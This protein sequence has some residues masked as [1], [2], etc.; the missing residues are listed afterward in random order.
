MPN[1]VSS[2]IRSVRF[3]RH[4]LFLSIAVCGGA[5]GA[6]AQTTVTLS[7][8]AHIN[9]DLTIQGGN[10]ARVDFSD[11][12]SLATKVSSEAYTRRILMK[13]DTEHYIPANA[14]IKSA[15]LQLVLKKAENSERRPLTA[16]YVT[17]SF[18]KRQANWLYYRDG[19]P[20]SRRGGDLG[21]KFGVTYVGNAVG[22][23]YTFDLT[24]L[25]QRTVN[26]DFGSRYTRLALIDRGAWTDGN[27]REFHSTRAA[28]P[29][30]RPRLVITYG[31]SASAAPK[32][33]APTSQT[34][35]PATTG[36]TLRVMQWN[37]HKTKGSDGV[38]NPARIV[39]VIANQNPHVVSLNEVNFF[40]G[41][42]AWDFDMGEKLRALLQ[43]KTGVTWYKQNVNV[44]GS[45]RGYG[46]VLLSRYRP[47]STGT[48]L[49]SNDRGVAEM[50]IV[51]N[52]RVINL[53]S[54]HME[55]ANASWR[56]R[57]I[58]EALAWIRGFGV[59]R[60][61]M[62]DF[63]MWPNTADYKLVATPHQ[64][65]W[66][67]AQNAGTATAYN[68]TGN[69]HGGSRFDY[70]FYSRNSYLTLKSM[71]VVDSRVGKVKAADHDPV[72]AVFTVK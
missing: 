49:L 16:Y 56:P 39:T 70:V 21:E 9:A 38:C 3:L 62:G 5:V 23:T 51:V 27:Y 2:N 14:V 26:G 63:N 52:G 11:D 65:A 4:L 13:F 37:V 28:N 29:A 7:Q 32:P 34:Q 35:T 19:K 67:T 43:Q 18:V 59:P 15:K 33:Q 71:A 47:G 54:T 45:G 8:P 53:F 55:Y 17:K 10:Y 25:V 22:S 42:C 46:N 61:I 24:A 44:Y 69:T 36:T 64:D 68:G 66:I 72:V 48:H 12:D 31:G 20:W 50:S 41:E 1:V 40:S 58:S 57:Q 60:I 6:S 30:V